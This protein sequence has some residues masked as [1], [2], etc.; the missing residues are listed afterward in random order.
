MRR[1]GVEAVPEVSAHGGGRRRWLVV[2]ALLLVAAGVGYGVYRSTVV[3]LEE[4]PPLRPLEPRELSAYLERDQI[5]VGAYQSMLMLQGEAERWLGDGREIA[6]KL[7]AERALWALEGPLAREVLTAEQVLAKLDASE[8]QARMYPLELA[9][10]LTALLRERG[11]RAMV[12]EAWELEGTGSPA[13]PSGLLGYFVTAVYEGDASE[14][15]SYLDPWGGRQALPSSLRVLRDTEVI[16]AA[17]GIEAARIFTGSGDGAKA[18]PLI[19]NA[20]LLDPVSPTLRGVNATVLVQSGGLPQA[21]RELE[22]ARQLRPDGPRQL[23]IVQL[24][25]AQAGLL[26]MSGELRAAEAQFNEGQRVVAEVLE[27]WPRY[28]RAHVMMATIHLGRGD[29]ERATLELEAAEALSPD[30]P[31]LWTIW[32]QHDLEQGDP[33]AGASKMKR[34]LALDP[35]NWQLQIQAARV[36]HDAGDEELAA[37]Q[38]AAAVARV[39]ASKRAE[40]QRFLEEAMGPRALGRDPIAEGNTGRDLQLPD[41][42]IAGPRPASGSP[43]EPGLILGDPSNLRLRDPDQTLKLD[44]DE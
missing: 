15:T 18:L 35:E 8:E 31:M 33:I 43:G 38:A 24:L 10:A 6:A 23:N 41:P 5:D 2:G 25:L 4:T 14:P 22:A 11:V 20:L 13:D 27:Q 29:P 44:L 26:E 19:E 7:K 28:G 30:S 1:G 21:L 40:V 12:A 32:A 16:A 42:T 36:F 3:T 17:L 37:E 9:S 34:A 39:P